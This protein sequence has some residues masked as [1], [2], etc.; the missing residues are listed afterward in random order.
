MRTPAEDL[1][2]LVADVLRYVPEHP[3]ADR[4]TVLVDVLDEHGEDLE[5][6]L[7]AL[8]PEEQTRIGLDEIQTFTGAEADRARMFDLLAHRPA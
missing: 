1:A 8:S 5:K 3:I 4:A 6:L 7:R 2:L